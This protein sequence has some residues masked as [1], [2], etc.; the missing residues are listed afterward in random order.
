MLRPALESIPAECEIVIVDTG[1]TDLTIEIA[2]EYT[3]HVFEYKWINDFSAAR[4]F[5]SSKATGDHILIMDADERLNSNA[6][7]ILGGFTQCCPSL[8]GTVTIENI[9]QDEIKRHRMV[10]FFPNHSSYSFSGVVHEQVFRDGKPAPFQHTGLIVTHYG[11]DA[12]YYTEKS[13]AER[14]LPL[15]IEHLKRHPRDGYMLYQMGKL[16]YG[17]SKLD[18]AEQYLTK[19]MR[20]GDQSNLYYP[21]MLVLLGYVLQAAN[22]STEAMNILRKVELNYPLFPDLP[23]LMGLLAMDTGEIPEI[24]RCFLKALAIGE[25][26]HYTSVAGTGSFKAAYNLGIYY[27]LTGNNHKAQKYYTESAKLGYNPAKERLQGL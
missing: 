11:Y 9:M 13:K 3:D 16:Y 19:S 24:E 15:Y 6:L 25:T 14:Y 1:S 7:Q 20:C 5:C 22:R 8:A 17:M 10:R 2:R 12:A 21:V 26:S 23:F 18:E 27:E 4:N